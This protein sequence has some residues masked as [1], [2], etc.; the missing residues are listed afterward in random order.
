MD[1][2]ALMLPTPAEPPNG[3]YEFKDHSGDFGTTHHQ[4][5]ASYPNGYGASVVRGMYT[6]GGREGFFEL[7]V[8][9][10][11]ALCYATPVTSDVVGWLTP[12]QVVEHLHKIAHLPKNELCAHRSRE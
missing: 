10:G 12:E 2:I 7:A 8:R 4:L 9:H 1:Q 6:Y 3:E 11:D 5:L